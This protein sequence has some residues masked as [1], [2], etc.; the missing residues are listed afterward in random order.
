MEKANQRQR[1][2][3]LLSPLVGKRNQHVFLKTHLGSPMLQ[4]DNYILWLY[5]L[6]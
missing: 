1:L 2:L 4:Q 5:F 3:F 6:M